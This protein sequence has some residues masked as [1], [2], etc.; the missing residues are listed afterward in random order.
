MAKY[1]GLRTEGRTA[2]A[3]DG[4]NVAYLQQ[5]GART[6]IRFVGNSNTLTVDASVVNVAKALSDRPIVELGDSI[7][8]LHAR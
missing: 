3:V 1:G 4:D 6:D 2:V 8:I 5:N 7:P